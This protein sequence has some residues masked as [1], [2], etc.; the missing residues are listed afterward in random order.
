MIF[1][2]LLYY[3]MVWVLRELKHA[4]VKKEIGI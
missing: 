4:N 3:R 2:E 1:W